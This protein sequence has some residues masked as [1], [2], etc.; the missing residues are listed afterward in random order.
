[1]RSWL[2][3]D[4]HGFH[5]NLKVPTDVDMVIHCGDCSNTHNPHLNYVEVTNFMDWFDWLDIKHKI[6]VPGNHDTSIEAGL[7]DLT[8]Y[9][10]ITPLI[11][12]LVTIEG[13]KIFGSPYTPRYGDW[14]FMKNRN[15][16]ELVWASMPSADIVVTH[17]PPK[18]YLDL[19]EDID[20]RKNLIHVGCKSLA[21]KIV[22]I[23]PKVHCFGHIH[24]ERNA[25][26]YGVFTSQDDIMYVNASCLNHHKG[27]VYNGHIIEV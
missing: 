19:T 17:G 8:Q 11:H 18:G 15:R 13:L 1:M 24:S 7:V 27:G 25:N 20:D 10:S 2:V 9:K 22:E 21:N 12:E 16:M 23:A 4:T 6:F 5:H 3:S 26:N 14:A